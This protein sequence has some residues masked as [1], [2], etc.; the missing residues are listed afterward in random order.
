ME[1][2]VAGMLERV[3]DLA[4]H[5]LRI[6]VTVERVGG[7]TAAASSLGT[8]FRSAVAYAG[9]LGF[10]IVPGLSLRG[11]PPGV[12]AVPL[13]PCPPIRYV[14]YTAAAEA[15]RT[16]PVQAPAAVAVEEVA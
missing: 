10:A 13:G 8:A 11:A 7:F 15:V 6:L 4:A 14:G 2:G 1:P 16:Q 9:G 3:S 12:T 5:D